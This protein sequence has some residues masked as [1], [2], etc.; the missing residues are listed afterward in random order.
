MD[1]AKLI[2][3]V[4][5]RSPLW[6]QQDRQYTNRRFTDQ[7]WDEIAQEMRSSSKFRFHYNYIM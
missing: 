3:Q 7:L 5:M 4:Y 1:T 2:S 6:D